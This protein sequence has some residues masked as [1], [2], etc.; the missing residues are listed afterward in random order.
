[1]TVRVEHGDRWP[2]S[3]RPCLLLRGLPWPLRYTYAMQTQMKHIQFKAIPEEICHCTEL[4]AACCVDTC[5]LGSLC[6]CS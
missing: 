1:M 3:L 2:S 6:P 4:P 5:P